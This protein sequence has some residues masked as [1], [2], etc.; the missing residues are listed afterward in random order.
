MAFT[1]PTSPSAG[2]SFTHGDSRFVYRTSPNRWVGGGYPGYNPFAGFAGPFAPLSANYPPAE[3][4]SWVSPGNGASRF[5]GFAPD[6]SIEPLIYPATGDTIGGWW[7]VQGGYN[8]STQTYANGYY[9]LTLPRIASSPLADKSDIDTDSGFSLQHN[10]NP[11]SAELTENNMYVNDGED[12]WSTIRA[13]STPISATRYNQYSNRPAGAD[14]AL[15]TLFQ[16]STA[17]IDTYHAT[18]RPDYY[19]GPALEESQGLTSSA[20]FGAVDRIELS[21]GNAAALTA[22]ISSDIHNTTWEF[23]RGNTILSETFWSNGGGTQTS[24]DAHSTISN[25]FRIRVY[26]LYYT[27]TA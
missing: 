1:F 26:D 8:T 9:G 12:L 21:F 11:A 14:A 16:I 22:D 23:R 13:N 10:N 27:Q 2:D 6:D 5:W 15:W 7:T 19:N 3:S 20:M 24:S 17:T 25:H 4:G 18:L